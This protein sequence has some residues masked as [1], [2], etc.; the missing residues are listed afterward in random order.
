MI[1]EIEK[2][3]SFENKLLSWI[4]EYGGDLTLVRSKY[5]DDLSELEELFKGKYRNTYFGSIHKFTECEVWSERADDILYELTAYGSQST[6]K[7]LQ[8]YSQLFLTF[9]KIM[10]NSK[11]VQNVKCWIRRLETFKYQNLEEV[12]AILSR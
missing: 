12:S 8:I 6:F 2:C 5:Q 3:E 9:K 4:E 11:G 7:A 1:S 10:E